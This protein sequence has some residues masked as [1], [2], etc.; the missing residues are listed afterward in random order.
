MSPKSKL[1]AC[2]H[3]NEAL[4][5]GGA[6]SDEPQKSFD[7][8]E[9]AILVILEENCETFW[10]EEE[11]GNWM[12]LGRAKI[13]A[14]SVFPNSKRIKHVTN[15][16]LAGWSVGESEEEGEGNVGN[17]NHQEADPSPRPHS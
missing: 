4:G 16:N 5:G 15:T 3:Q 12:I 17:E 2:S 13:K 11:Q 8:G 10:R 9:V 1:L 6:E 14:C 7:Q